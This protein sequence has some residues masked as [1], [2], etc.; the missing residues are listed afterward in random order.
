MTNF[1]IRRYKLFSPNVNWLTSENKWYLLY[2]P[3]GNLKRIN[4][5]LI[6]QNIETYFPLTITDSRNALG[7]ARIE[8]LFDS[9]LLVRLS[10]SDIFS[11]LTLSERTSFV[12]RLRKPVSVSDDEVGE[13]KIF[14]ETFT[15]VSVRGIYSDGHLLRNPK[16]VS[17]GEDVLSVPC[18]A[19]SSLGCML[20]SSKTKNLVSDDRGP[21]MIYR[22]LYDLNMLVKGTN[23]K[24]Y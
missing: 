24:A 6:S 9:H 18:L 14:L 5:E 1:I 2:L 10:S 23:K 16:I 13:M 12:Y 11:I 7:E 17:S 8:P 3:V 4:E 15:N 20:F 19:V 21:R 22:F